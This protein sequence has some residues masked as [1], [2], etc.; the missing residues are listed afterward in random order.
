MPKAQDG[1]RLIHDDASGIESA[2]PGKLSLE[3]VTFHAQT[4]NQI[5]KAL[6]FNPDPVSES[7]KA[8]IRRRQ[9]SRFH[10]AG[11]AHK[12]KPVLLPRVAD[13]LQGDFRILWGFTH[14]MDSAEVGG[15]VPARRSSATRNAP[16]GSLSAGGPLFR[17]GGPLPNGGQRRAQCGGGHRFGAFNL[18]SIGPVM[19]FRIWRK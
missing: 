17:R 2:Q 6:A 12:G 5:G 9:R 16:P 7:D 14:G 19:R 1:L 4:R 15:N 13:Y 11:E 18:E 10:R 3:S 8:I